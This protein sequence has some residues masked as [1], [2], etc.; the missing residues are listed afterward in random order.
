M[1]TDELGCADM[2]GRR[3]VRIAEA[4]QAHSVWTAGRAKGT[5][6]GRT[7]KRRSQRNMDGNEDLL[8][9][10]RRHPARAC[11]HDAHSRVAL[12]HGSM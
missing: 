7:D 2:N 1:Q 12:W 3:A 9:D 11:M 10:K 4:V 8:V 6:M 5:R